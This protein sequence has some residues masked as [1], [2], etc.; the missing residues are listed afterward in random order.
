MNADWEA[1]PKPEDIRNICCLML[2]EI[3][4]ILVTTP[5]LESLK[6][7]YPQASLTV[8]VRKPLARLLEGNPQVDHL[9]Y[10]DNRSI[11]TKIQ[12]LT[13][14]LFRSLILKR[15]D[16]WVDLHTPT[17]N[18]VCSN[19]TIFKRNHLI[20]RWAVPRYSLGFQDLSKPVG[21]SHGVSF[22]DQQQL[23]NENIVD[24]TLRLTEEIFS[25]SGYEKYFH[26][27]DQDKCW[28]A[29]RLQNNSHAP[30]FIGLFFGSKQPVDVWPEYRLLE[31]AE[32]LFSQ[33]P[34]ATLVLLGGKSEAPVAEMLMS[35]FDNIH[36]HSILNF[37][38]VANL[39]QTGAL[40]TLCRALIS[41]DSGPMHIADALSVPIVA[42]FSSKNHLT[43]WLPVQSQ[44]EVLNVPAECGPCFKSECDKPVPCIER[45][46]PAQVMVALTRILSS[47][48]AGSEKT[49]S[50][51]E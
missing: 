42:L 19:E 47:K 44:I 8:I 10:Y 45:I 41:T 40:M 38:G 48:K 33:Y 20:R 2:A 50:E 4:D 27:F 46:E 31:L 26:L 3:G 21:H 43:V 5:T 51:K 29:S 25:G 16:L 37:C 11:V 7:K 32:L 17:F 23:A 39:G 1:L 34:K 30:L 14:L 36:R 22:P 12:L 18:T 49:D 6:K 24:S 13:G 9:I 28:A 15:V 35:H